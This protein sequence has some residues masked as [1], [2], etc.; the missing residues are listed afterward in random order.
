MTPKNEFIALISSSLTSDQV[1]SIC[2]MTDA[3]ETKLKCKYSN[4]IQKI[5]REIKALYYE[6][7]AS[8][9]AS[10]KDYDTFVIR[11]TE[12]ELPYDHIKYVIQKE[13]EKELAKLGIYTSVY[14]HVKKFVES[15]NTD[16]ER[17]SITT[18]I[19]NAIVPELIAQKD[20]IERLK[21]TE[22]M[23]ILQEIAS[24]LKKGE[25]ITRIRFDV[26]SSSRNCHHHFGI[27]ERKESCPLY[28]RTRPEAI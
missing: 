20:A 14:N 16:V 9:Y 1:A 5:D 18:T 3:M 4:D 26:N 10:G 23:E 12:M 28:K 2:E 7:C 21:Y 17:E 19:T 25:K 11:T 6:L 22:D 24:K 8:F 27:R 15:L 13:E